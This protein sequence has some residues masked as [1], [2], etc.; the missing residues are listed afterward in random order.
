MEKVRKGFVEEMVIYKPSSKGQ[1]D[2]SSWYSKGKEPQRGQRELI[3][4]IGK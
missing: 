2:Y 4:V 1:I 3:F